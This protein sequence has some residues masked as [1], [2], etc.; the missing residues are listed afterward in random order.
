MLNL[1]LFLSTTRNS[2][3]I[4]PYCRLHLSVRRAGLKEFFDEEENLEKSA[5]AVGRSWEKAELRTRNNEDL[6]KLW[7]VNPR[8]RYLW[9]LTA[10]GRASGI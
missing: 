8:Y 1:F 4:E 5:V 6:H 9:K 3:S 2:V 7:Y 10:W